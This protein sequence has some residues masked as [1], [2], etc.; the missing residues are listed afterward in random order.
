[1]MPFK[2]SDS[3]RTMPRQPLPLLVAQARAG[4]EDFDGPRERRER[5]AE[6]VGDVRRHAAEAREPIGLPHPLLH[7]PERREVFARRHGAHARAERRAQGRERHEHRDPPAI[8]PGDDRLAAHRA[9]VERMADRVPASC[10]HR[11]PTSSQRMPVMR[12]ASRPVISRAARLNAGHATVDVEHDESRADAVEDEV[13]KGLEVTQ[14][15]AAG[16]QLAL[17]RPV[18]LGE[19][20]GDDGDDEKG[21]AVEEDGDD[22][23]RASFRQA[24]RSRNAMGS[25][26]RPKTS[27]L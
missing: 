6:L 25:T 8:G 13:S 2:R 26:V 12:S 21:A 10:R 24:P 22:L 19:A 16:L 7:A 27:A 5:V 20:A 23:E 17:G 3:R 9:I 15:L 14:V 1:M 4:A 18:P 11:P